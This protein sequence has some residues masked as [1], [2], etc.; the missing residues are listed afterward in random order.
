[1]SVIPAYR[2]AYIPSVADPAVEPAFSDFWTVTD[3]A[4]RVGGAYDVTLDTA[5]STVQTDQHFSTV[6]NWPGNK[7]FYRVLVRQYIYPEFGDLLSNGLVPATYFGVT[8]PPPARTGGTRL[9]VNGIVKKDGE[10]V[11]PPSTFDSRVC[12]RCSVVDASGNEVGVRQQ[13]AFMSGDVIES[14]YTHRVDPA[15]LD[16][17]GANVNT[18]I[19]PA[20]MDRLVVEIGFQA[21]YFLSGSPNELDLSVFTVF[22]DEAADF[23]VH[24]STEDKNPGFSLIYWVQQLG[25]T[26]NLARFTKAMRPTRSALR[27]QHPPVPPT[28][29]FLGEEFFG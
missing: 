8:G 18:H 28:G 16:W 4:T 10:I 1:M 26:G 23:L 24:L 11:T 27:I 6:S 7:E 20:A 14:H 25:G 13:S 3:G 21:S 22:G 5:F 15:A 9:K 17:S 2:N 29:D 12:Y 19:H